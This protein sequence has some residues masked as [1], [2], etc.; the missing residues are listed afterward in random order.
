MVKQKDILGINARSSDY[1]RLNNRKARMRADDK[2][3]TK[4]MLRRVR[5]PHPKLLGKLKNR[6]KSCA[7]CGYKVNEVTSD[8]KNPMMSKT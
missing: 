7:A 8:T 6:I 1:L 3:V 4:R 2:L 5:I